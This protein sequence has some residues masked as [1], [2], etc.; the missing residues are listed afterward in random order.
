MVVDQVPQITQM[1]EAVGL[2][3]AAESGEQVGP[4]EQRPKAL[5]LERQFTEMLVVMVFRT[6]TTMMP[7]AAAVLPKRVG[8]MGLLTAEV[9]LVNYFLTLQVMEPHQ[10]T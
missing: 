6:V 7:L 4:E 2:A 5:Y 8:I 1:L 9:A 3:A 10:E